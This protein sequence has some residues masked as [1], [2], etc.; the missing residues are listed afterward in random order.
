MLRGLEFEL[1]GLCRVHNFPLY[2]Q[3]I[4]HMGDGFVHVPWKTKGV[5]FDPLTK[6]TGQ[7]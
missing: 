4:T 3:H 2:V 6:L 1:H 5:Y 7:G